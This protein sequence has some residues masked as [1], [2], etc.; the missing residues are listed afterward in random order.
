MDSD[1]SARKLMLSRTRS[2]PFGVAYSLQMLSTMMAAVRACVSMVAL[3]LITLLSQAALAESGVILIVGDSLSAGY[4]IGLDRSWPAL[5]QQRLAERGYPHRVEN[6]SIS[7]ETTQGGLTR[8]GALLERHRPQLVIVELGA[9]DGLRG[10]AIPEAE[11]NLTRMIEM[12]GGHGID[13]LLFEMR[14]PPNYGPVYADRFEG[15]YERLGE[16]D[17]VRLV[18][19]FLDGVVLNRSLMQNDGLHPNADAQ[20]LI[21]NNVWDY[22]EDEL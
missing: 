4:G 16:R 5:L 3:C 18:P 11:R 17:D 2:G 6:A 21:L 20:P 1:C 22:I 19:F 10:I 15:M 13:T 14:I 12:S 8:L 7:G 9:N